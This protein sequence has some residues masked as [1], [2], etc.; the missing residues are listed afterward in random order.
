[1]R[2][3][4]APRKTRATSFLRLY[5]NLHNFR[6]DCSFHTW[7]YRIVTNLCLDGLRK[8]RARREESTPMKRAAA[9]WIAWIRSKSRA[10]SPTRK[11]P[12][13]QPVAR[14]PEAARHKSEKP[15]CPH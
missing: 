9:L 2:T 6:V 5:R 11:A 13:E 12:A 10:P 3:Y 8:R 4:C 14:P 1:M 15:I 7:L